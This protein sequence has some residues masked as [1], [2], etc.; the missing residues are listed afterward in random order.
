MKV[1]ILSGV[2][3]TEIGRQFGIGRGTVSKRCQDL[4]NEIK[5]EKQKLQ[6]MGLKKCTKC[7]KVRS[8]KSFGVRSDTIKGLSAACRDC[9]PKSKP[10]K[11]RDLVC[12]HPACGVSFESCSADRKYCDEHTNKTRTYKECYNEAKKYSSRS[13]FRRGSPTHYQKCIATGWCGLFF[14]EVFGDKLAFGFNRSNFIEVCERNN[15]GNGILYLI[16]CWDKNEIFY[17]IGITS[18]SVE[19]RYAKKSDMPYHYEILWTIEM[20]GGKIWD[21]ENWF[22]KATK[23]IRYQPT[24]WP[25]TRSTETFKCHGNCKILRNPDV[26]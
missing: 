23:N 10:R 20:E 15:D 16:K 12:Q 17:K 6:D 9:V 4:L 7:C 5:E 2:S 21:M 8:L 14:Q 19:I 1:M 18:N 24:I 25:S 11:R 22:K 3:L 13:E 26:T